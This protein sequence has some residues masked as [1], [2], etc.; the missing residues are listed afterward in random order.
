VAQAANPVA[1]ASLAELVPPARMLFGTDFPYR[2]AREIAEGLKTCDFAPRE[3]A[4]IDR[5]N[6]ARLF[7]RFAP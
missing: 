4:A 3:R 6:A 7:P 1:L 5:G 2:T